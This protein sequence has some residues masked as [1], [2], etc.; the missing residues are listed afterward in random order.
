M[1]VK[2]LKNLIQPCLLAIF[3]T[4]CSAAYATPPRY[5]SIT[6]T[7]IAANETHVF[8]IRNVSDNEGSHYINN[9]HRFL[10]AQSLQTGAVDDQCLLDITRHIYDDSTNTIE[11]LPA[12]TGEVDF[13]KLLK[14]R[15]TYPLA[16]GLTTTWDGS[17][18]TL[19]IQNRFKLTKQGLHY[20][21]ALVMPVKVLQ[22]KIAANLN[23]TMHIMP[24]DL[25]LIDLLI[26]ND[27]SYT[28]DLNNCVVHG[29]DALISA[30]QRLVYLSCD[31]GGYD[32]AGY[33]IYLT[34][35]TE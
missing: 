33:Q 13:L 14:Q 6:D 7:P 23:P 34:V 31:D 22:L 3:L 12:P 2:T 9:T 25:G 8:L 5:V 11:T 35:T 15:N 24:T 10:V 1:N 26:L 30:G 4:L 32:V 28:V 16:M 21:G 27:N 17:T 29:S 18:D 19:I 20:N